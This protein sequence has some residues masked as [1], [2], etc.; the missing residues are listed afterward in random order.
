M[1]IA[2]PAIG[3]QI[4]QDFDNCK[5]FKI[6]NI[7]GK[8]IRDEEKIETSVNGDYKMN[9]SN[10]FAQSGVAILIAGKIGDGAINVLATKNIRTIKGASG[11]V[12]D[13]VESFLR[14][15]LRG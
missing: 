3:D 4:D 5:D 8:V 7:E 12:R 14:G 2:V 6:F 1:K 11:M 13:A 10:Q 15:E 9:F